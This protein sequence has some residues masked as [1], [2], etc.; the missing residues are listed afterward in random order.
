MMG[1]K[2]GFFIAVEGIDGAGKRTLCSI[3][4][5]KLELNNN[6]NNKK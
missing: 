1:E 4:K 2:K 6:Y 5:Q 3:I